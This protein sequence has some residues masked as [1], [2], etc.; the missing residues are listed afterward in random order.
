[1]TIGEEEPILPDGTCAELSFTTGD[2]KS[3]HF[4]G[5]NDIFRHLLLTGGWHGSKETVKQLTTR[6]FSFINYYMDKVNEPKIKALF[7]TQEY[8]D[9]IGNICRDGWAAQVKKSN[10][11]SVIDCKLRVNRTREKCT[12]VRHK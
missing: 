2:G 1:M 9:K 4:T 7:E 10:P 8:K 6:V 5:R 11:R 3:C 12:S